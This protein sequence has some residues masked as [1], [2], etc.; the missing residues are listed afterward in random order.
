MEKET[1]TAE[2]GKVSDG[3]TYRYAYGLDRLSVRVSPVTTG[4]GGIVQNGA[5]KLW[6]HQDRL[7]STDFLTDNVQGKV[8]SYIDYDAWGAPLK[9]AV[10][11]LDARELDLVIEYT[12]HPYDQV[13]GVYFAQARMYDAA[14]KRFMAADPVRGDVSDPKT[15]TQYVYCVDNPVRF[16]DPS[17][18]WKSDVHYNDTKRW[19]EEKGFKNVTIS[20]K[21]SVRGKS[22]Q[23]D[24]TAAYLIAQADDDVDKNLNTTPFA[25]WSEENLS[26]HFDVRYLGYM[27]GVL[28]TRLKQF[29]KQ[30]DEVVRL[31]GQG[32][33]KEAL[34]AF[35]KG[36]HPLQDYYAHLDWKPRENGVGYIHT[37]Y[38]E[39][40]DCIYGEVDSSIDL[41]DDPRYD[42]KWKEV[43]FLK[44]DVILKDNSSNPKNPN[45]YET[46]YSVEDKMVYVATKAAGGES[47]RYVR[48]RTATQKALD[49]FKKAFDDPT[50][51]NLVIFKAFYQNPNF[52]KNM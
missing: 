7:G 21:V 44:V 19:A 9:K 31:L 22:I 48:T 8:A 25:Y 30:C 16:S 24:N 13:L 17:G 50:P 47:H 1:L 12:G 11:K 36:L 28:D 18:M 49:N 38:Y 42:L 43:S 32:R 15:L 52:E 51:A 2:N 20:E 27:K 39:Q 33:M 26:W 23:V 34:Q 5:V 35:G 3:F 45:N 6:Y 41:F 29:E 46:M 10:L 4:G 40:L 37:A 14:D